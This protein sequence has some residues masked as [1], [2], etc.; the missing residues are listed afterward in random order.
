L[1]YVLAGALIHLIQRSVRLRTWTFLIASTRLRQL[2][3]GQLLR[4]QLVGLLANQLLPI[5]E[6]LKVWA[7]AKR[8][9][10]VLLAS[11]SLVADMALHSLLIGLVGAVGAW[12]HPLPM[13]WLA[14][15]VMTGGSLLTLLLAHYWGRE[16]DARLALTSS[17]AHGYNFAETVCQ[18]GV[19]AL[20][21]HAIGVPIDVT[22]VL[23]L[24]PILYLTDLVMFTPSGL[25]L[26]EAV[27]A[28]ALQLMGGVPSQVGV[29]MGLIITA[30]LFVA[31]AVGGSLALLLP[32][33]ADAD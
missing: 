18:V 11:R 26:R 33:R 14:A 6:A 3:F 19:Y 15:G 30:M 4:I 10:D 32:S 17:R 1:P 13:L 9:R 29:A 22:Q 12:L 5:S 28:L 23:A 31:A 7:V 27:F 8:P 21:A 2:R 20:A 16:H 25:G 24:S